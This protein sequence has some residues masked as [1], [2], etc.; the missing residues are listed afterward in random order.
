MKQNKTKKRHSVIFL[1]ALIAVVGLISYR[2]ISVKIEIN[3][4][5]KVL[6]EVSAQ[7]ELQLKSNEE[8]E[9]KINEENEAQ[10]MERIARERLG[11]VMPG[12]KTYYDIAAGE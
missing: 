12:E 7:Y 2:M 1:A 8:L 4:Q 11:M 5:Q 3:N 6:D 9:R 10:Y